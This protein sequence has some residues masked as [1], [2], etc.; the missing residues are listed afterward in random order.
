MLKPKKQR[1]IDNIR[2]FVN[3]LMIVILIK[4]TGCIESQTNQNIGRGYVVKQIFENGK[5]LI[6]TERGNLDL[7]EN[8]FDTVGKNG[9]WLYYDSINQLKKRENWFD[10]KRFGYQIEYYPSDSNNPRVRFF[11]FFNLSSRQIF[12]SEYNFAG[13][14]KSF[15]DGS[16]LYYAYNRNIFKVNE[17]LDMIIFFADPPGYTSEVT[18]T[19]SDL[20][21][22]TTNSQKVITS[23][24]SDVDQLFYAS[25][26]S[27]E[28]EYKRKGI[29]VWQVNYRLKDGS[30]RT[31]KSTNSSLE[32][33]VI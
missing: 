26:Y 1:N 5:N 14:I 20:S 23:S 10:G 15:T 7:I 18:I 29:Y 30:G 9:I 32:V 11:S 16:P 27:L 33:K 2:N 31:I 3:I 19:E 6:R 12:K 21:D 22:T 8:G 28:K 4:I 24:S 25:R 13:G 17:K